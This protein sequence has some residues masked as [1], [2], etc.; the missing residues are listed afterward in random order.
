METPT[1]LSPPS[2]LVPVPEKKKNPKGKL[3]TTGHNLQTE[4][5]ML[6]QMSSMPHS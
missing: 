1:L 3:V 4:K 5:G 6:F 2:S